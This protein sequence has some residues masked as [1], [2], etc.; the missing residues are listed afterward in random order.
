M[1]NLLTFSVLAVAVLADETLLVI[2]TINYLDRHVNQ[3]VQ[4]S[5]LSLT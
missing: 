5:D 1:K 4:V 3:Y 2:S